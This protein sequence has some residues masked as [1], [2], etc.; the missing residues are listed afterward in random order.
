MSFLLFDNIHPASTSDQGQDDLQISI[1]RVKYI[2][3]FNVNCYD[4]LPRLR[5]LCVP[6]SSSKRTFSHRTSQMVSMK[7]QFQGEKLTNISIPKKKSEYKFMQQNFG[8][9]HFL[10]L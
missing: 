7:A 9:S 10:P 6:G 8:S 4:T 5:F 2:K 1:L 3:L